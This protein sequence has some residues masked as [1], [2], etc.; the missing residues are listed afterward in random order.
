MGD[1]TVAILANYEGIDG[2]LDEKI[3]REALVH[4]KRFNG[5]HALPSDVHF[6]VNYGPIEASNIF[7][8]NALAHELR[9]LTDEQWSPL[10][11]GEEEQILPREYHNHD[12]YT[13]LGL[14]IMPNLFEND[15]L[16]KSLRS[17]V[18]E[19]FEGVDIT[20]P[21]LIEGL[22]F[23]RIDEDNRN[24]I[25]LHLTTDTSVRNI[26][27]NKGFGRNLIENAELSRYRKMDSRN[28]LEGKGIYTLK[29]S[30][31]MGEFWISSNLS[32]TDVHG[33]T[34]LTTKISEDK[35][36]ELKLCEAQ[37]EDGNNEQYLFLIK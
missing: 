18:Q 36:K 7:F 15:Y 3:I 21:V 20:H 2:L 33:R 28:F 8:A 14:I 27:T 5:T 1:I 17:Q 13:T 10:T 35:C 31:H 34:Y 22:L 26:D 12:T 25:L 16:G 19:S 37:F 29:Y 32:Q 30:G 24:E 6:T 11:E 4:M 9:V 23:P